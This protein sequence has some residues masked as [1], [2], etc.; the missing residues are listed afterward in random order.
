MKDPIVVRLADRRVFV[1]FWPGSGID[2][3]LKFMWELS[4]RA[5][6]EAVVN[7]VSIVMDGRKGR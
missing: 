5:R 3:I 7:G 1:D 4:I 6:V 2:E